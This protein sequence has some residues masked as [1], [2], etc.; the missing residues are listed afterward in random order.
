MNRPAILPP[1]R[2]TRRHCRSSH[3]NNGGR[4]RDLRGI[5]S[6]RR[7]SARHHQAHRGG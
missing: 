3:S 1:V 5:G 4:L 6:D 2:G 7:L